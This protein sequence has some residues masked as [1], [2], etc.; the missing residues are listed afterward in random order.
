MSWFQHPTRLQRQAMLVSAIELVASVGHI[1]YRPAT[2]PVIHTNLRGLGDALVT[3]PCADD[4]DYVARAP[5]LLFR[6]ALV[7]MTVVLLC[8]NNEE[9]MW[10]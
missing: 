4:A 5:S 8:L 6:L 2:R 10:P 1:S 9:I 3:L 7:I